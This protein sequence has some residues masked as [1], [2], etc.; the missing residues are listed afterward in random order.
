[1][2][3]PPAVDAVRD[4]HERDALVV[5]AEHE[6]GRA[7]DRVG[8]VDVMVI[9]LAPAWPKSLKVSGTP[10]LVAAS[11]SRQEPPGAVSPVFIT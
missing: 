4:R 9:G 5:A 1:M 7:V 8:A 11:G 2:D 10:P 3:R 6:V